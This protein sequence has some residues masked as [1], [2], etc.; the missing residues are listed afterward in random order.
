MD[1]HSTTQSVS[2]RKQRSVDNFVSNR[3]NKMTRSMDELVNS[4][5]DRKRGSEE[6]QVLRCSEGEVVRQ[7]ARVRI[8]VWHR[9]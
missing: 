8:L 9:L 3:P 7:S 5:D 4:G 2:D 1:Q 6:G